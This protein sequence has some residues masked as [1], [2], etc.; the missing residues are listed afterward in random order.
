M[1]TLIVTIVCTFDSM[2]IIYVTIEPNL[3]SVLL[4][5]GIPHVILELT[6]LHFTDSLHGGPSLSG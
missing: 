1:Q 6:L 5:K 2:W 3:T 4:R